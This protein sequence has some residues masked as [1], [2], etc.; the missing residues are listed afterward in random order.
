MIQQNLDLPFDIEDVVE[1]EPDLLGAVHVDT[2]DDE[3][4]TLCF[5][6]TDLN[7]DDDE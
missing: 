1:I 2:K 4:Y 6:T 7:D 5:I 3:T